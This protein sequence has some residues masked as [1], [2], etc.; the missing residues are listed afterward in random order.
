LEFAVIAVV[1]I[2]GFIITIIAAVVVHL[3][4]LP[5]FFTARKTSP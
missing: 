3:I 5:V 2:V 4:L 1:M